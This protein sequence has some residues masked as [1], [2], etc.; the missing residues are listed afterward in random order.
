M[1]EP[2]DGGFMFLHGL[3]LNNLGYRGRKAKSRYLDPF[4]IDWRR[5]ARPIELGVHTLDQVVPEDLP[6]RG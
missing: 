5:W 2:F 6:G 1:S 3:L 4:P